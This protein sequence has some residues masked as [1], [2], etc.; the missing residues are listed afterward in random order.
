MRYVMGMPQYPPP[1]AHASAS[2]TISWNTS[3]KPAPAPQHATVTAVDGSRVT[4]R[5][6][7]GSTRRYLATPQEAAVLRRL[8][9]RTIAF[10]VDSLR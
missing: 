8:I 2:V 6:Q 7:D 9:G 4:V 1:S 3:A 10:R 5:L